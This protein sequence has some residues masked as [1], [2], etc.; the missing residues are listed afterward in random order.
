MTTETSIQIIFNDESI[1]IPEQCSLKVMLSA[2]GHVGGPYA[3]ALNHAFVPNA[4]HGDILLKEG[5]VVDVVEPME[6]G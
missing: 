3:V 5:D 1:D 6:G 2:R 4:E